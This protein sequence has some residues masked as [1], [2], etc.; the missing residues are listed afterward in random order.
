[1]VDE[2]YRDF[3]FDERRVMLSTRPEKSIG[4]DEMWEQ[5]EGALAE[6]LRGAGIDYSI[7]AGDGAFY[8]PKIDFVVVDALKRPWQL[9]TDPARLRR[10]AR[11]LRPQ[12]RAARTA[13]RRG[14]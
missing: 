4:S 14:R 7:N 2:V 9:A 10:A 8:G 11:A 6:A 12:L 1:M 13:A 5:A 3:G